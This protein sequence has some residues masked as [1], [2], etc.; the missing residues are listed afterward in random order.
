[1]LFR[2]VSQSRYVEVSGTT[3]GIISLNAIGG[4]G[5]GTATIAAGTNIGVSQSGGTITINNTGAA[6]LSGVVNQI[7]YFNTTSTI[8][9]PS[10][11]GNDAMTWD[12]AN[13]YLGI[14][15]SG[16]GQKLDVLTTGNTFIRTNSTSISGVTGFLMANA[17]GT[18]GFRNQGNSGSDFWIRDD[19]Q[20]IVTGKQIGRAHV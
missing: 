4:T 10:G 6:A 1:M 3:S 5:G 18:W 11:S 9:T 2:S 16:P 7:P 8:T 12:A 17:T 13:K 19:S 15:T 14:G 20:A